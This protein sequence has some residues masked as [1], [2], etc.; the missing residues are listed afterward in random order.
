[1]VG[2]ILLL[3]TSYLRNSRMCHIRPFSLSW[4]ISRSGIWLRGQAD[5]LLTCYVCHIA[6]QLGFGS[7]LGIIGSNLVENKRQMVS[8]H[9]YRIA[10]FLW[11]SSIFIWISNTLFKVAQVGPQK[12]MPL[13][14]FSSA[15][16]EL[17]LKWPRGMGLVPVLPDPPSVP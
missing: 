4:I 16:R 15:S 3:N 8:F 1:M 17:I 6:L 9:R 7:F 11:K 2:E 13:C 5:H 10:L 14:L 12:Q